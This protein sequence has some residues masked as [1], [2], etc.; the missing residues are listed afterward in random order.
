MSRI[1]EQTRRTGT[2][3][4]DT[5]R[6]DRS[7]EPNVST[8]LQLEIERNRSM[9]EVHDDSVGD[10]PIIR[11]TRLL[12]EVRDDFYVRPESIWAY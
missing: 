3:E 5:D 8:P 11:R 12:V 10:R 4:A 2:V 6:I 1:D 7:K 9:K